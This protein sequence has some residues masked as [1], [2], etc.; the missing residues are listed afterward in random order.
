MAA[1]L[2]GIS[3]SRV[4]FHKTGPQKVHGPQCVAMCL[5]AIDEQTDT[6]THTDGNILITQ[7]FPPPVSKPPML[8]HLPFLSHHSLL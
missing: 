4:S 3:W 1:L 2:H 8:H 5:I 7:S 6:H